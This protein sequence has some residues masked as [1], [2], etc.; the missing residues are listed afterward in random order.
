QGGQLLH[1]PLADL[2]ELA[3]GV[4]DQDGLVVAEVGRGEQVAHQFSSSLPVLSPPGPGLPAE[5]RRASAGA[6]WPPAG[7]SSTASRPSASSSGARP[8]ARSEGGRFWP[9]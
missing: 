3:R 5:R 1:G 9:A 4:Q 6:A 8:V 2:G 7:P